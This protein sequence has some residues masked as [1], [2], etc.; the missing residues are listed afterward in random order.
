MKAYSLVTLLLF[1]LLLGGC[2]SVPVPSYKPP[3]ANTESLLQHQG[4]K[5]D[6]GQVTAAGGV[7]NTRLSVRGSSLEGTGANHTFSAYLQD[8]LTNELTTAGRFDH[9]AATRIDA[10]LTHNELDGSGFSKGTA[11]LGARFVVVRDGHSIYDKTLS[12]HHEWESSFMGA[13]AIP[14][15]IQNYPVAVQKLVGKLFQD[16]DFVKAVDGD[17]ARVSSGAP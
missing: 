16:G 15:T 4:S 8:A 6:V 9:N 7:P 12:V 2:A 3:I 13:I 5:L 11:D 17:A 10:T 14:A 1:S